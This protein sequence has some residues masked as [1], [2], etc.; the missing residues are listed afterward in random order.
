[1]LGAISLAPVVGSLLLYYFWKPQNFTNYG[2][3]ISS[4][5]LAG[6]AIAERD[7]G[8]FRLDEFRGDWIFL[9]ADT[10]A[11]DDYCN[12]KLYVM[13]QIRLTQGDDRERIQRVWI[14]TDGT[15]P[16]SAVETEYRGTRV[17]QP[18]SAE[19]LARLPAADS[20]RDHIYLVDPFGNLMMRFP[21][22]ADPQRV[23][24]DVSK[25]MKLSGGWI[26]NTK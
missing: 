19:F 9:M 6:V 17:V 26:Q 23:K 13:R 15:R 24:K 11:C 10:G 22:N 3:L 2:E 7:G 12:S 5:P 14:V 16:T 8:T 4:Q 18:A 25:L 20:P 21:R 1:M